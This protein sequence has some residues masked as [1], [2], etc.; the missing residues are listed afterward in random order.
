[1]QQARSRETSAAVRPGPACSHPLFMCADKDVAK[2]GVGLTAQKGA[3][4]MRVGIKNFGND[5]CSDRWSLNFKFDQNILKRPPFS[6]IFRSIIPALVVR[7]HQCLKAG[8][9]VTCRYTAAFRRMHQSLLPGLCS[10]VAPQ[11]LS[12]IPVLKSVLIGH[13]QVTFACAMTMAISCPGKPLI[14]SFLSRTCM[15]F[16]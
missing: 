13:A 4:L 11:S 2:G 3:F 9:L 5:T 8:I 15:S 7:G 14:T 16:P 6:Q 12:S 10:S 1:M